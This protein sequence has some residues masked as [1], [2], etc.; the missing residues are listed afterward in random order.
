M[1]R[2]LSA[3]GVPRQV[4]VSGSRHPRGAASAPFPFSSVQPLKS[5]HVKL[6]YM[7]KCDQG[8]TKRA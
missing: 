6:Q 2:V 7:L 5:K 3:N 1:N 8:V 4:H